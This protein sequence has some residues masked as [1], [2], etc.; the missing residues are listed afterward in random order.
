M[1]QSEVSMRA[2]AAGRKRTA[3]SITPKATLKKMWKHLSIIKRI[4]VQQISAG[5]RVIKNFES[6]EEAAA[7]V[8]C[9]RSWLTEILKGRR[10]NVKGKYFRYAD[11]ALRP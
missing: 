1:S 8:P 11:P 6:I 7:A 4:P 5:G 3:Y 2:F 10:E 9:D